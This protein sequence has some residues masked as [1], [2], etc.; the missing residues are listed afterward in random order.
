LARLLQR[1]KEHDSALELIEED[2]G[3]PAPGLSRLEV[4]ACAPGRGDL[5][6]SRTGLPPGEVVIARAESG[7]IWCTGGLV[8]CGRCLPCQAS[9]HL[10]C[11]DA[12][13]IGEDLPGGLASS[14][15]LPLESGFLA[16]LPE[17]RHPAELAAAAA[18]IAGGGTT[19]QAVASVG[20]SPG[21]A[22][23][24]R[25]SVGPGALP[26]RVLVSQGLRVTWI[27]E[28]AEAELEDDLRASVAVSAD[29]PDP[30]TLASPRIHLIDL[31]P[32]SEQ[33]ARLLGLARLSSS[34]SLLTH[35]PL[36]DDLNL[37]AALEGQAALRRISAIH[38]HLLLDLVALAFSGRV[39]VT[40]WVEALGLEQFRGRFG[41]LVRGE[42]DRW[43]V[44]TGPAGLR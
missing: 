9:S 23:V 21:E 26:L 7:A 32:D 38:P 27:T 34:C 42:A 19:Y 41:A 2:L 6:S 25:G 43:P 24:I 11:L 12:R 15:D 29:I 3:P 30:E 10:A 14:I 17:G 33:T 8:P 5:S 18:L 28:T 36:Q 40:P 20:M 22:V 44:F 4:L 35:S 39:E 31:Q 1:Q 13:R 16:P 37:V